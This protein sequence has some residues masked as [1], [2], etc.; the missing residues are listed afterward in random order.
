MGEVTCCATLF[1]SDV[2]SEK[3]WFSVCCPVRRKEAVASFKCVRTNDRRRSLFFRTNV[4]LLVSSCASEIHP[5]KTKQNNIITL[6][7]FGLLCLNLDD[8]ETSPTTPGGPYISSNYGDL[9]F[10]GWPQFTTA[11]E[12]GWLQHPL[13]LSQSVPVWQKLCGLPN[14]SKPCLEAVSVF[15]WSSQNMIISLSY[16]RLL[17]I[18]FSVHMGISQSVILSECLLK[19]M[20]TFWR[21]FVCF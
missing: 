16:N 8:F 10:Q 2:S 3:H 13:S 12:V 6:L 17:R 15:K 9:V 19:L 4:T 7:S 18:F 14:C 5:L 11:L 20:Q 1:V 21:T